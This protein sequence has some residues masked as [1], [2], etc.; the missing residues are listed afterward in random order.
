M[1]T[2]NTFSTLEEIILDTYLEGFTQKLVGLFTDRKLEF[3]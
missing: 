3:V 1:V 2:S